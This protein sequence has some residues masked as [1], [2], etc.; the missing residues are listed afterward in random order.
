M[1]PRP[2]P[3]NAGADQIYGVRA[4]ACFWV[5]ACNHLGSCFRMG[6]HSTWSYLVGEIVVILS[7]DFNVSGYIPT[8]SYPFQVHVYGP[9][10]A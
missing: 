7:G 1:V 3:P 10:P 9:P 6:V 4:D 8:L 5:G 2:R